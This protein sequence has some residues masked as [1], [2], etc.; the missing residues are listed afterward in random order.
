[1]NANF[2]GV[3]RYTYELLRRFPEKVEQISPSQ[4]FS[5]GIKGHIWEQLFLP[6]KLNGSLL[7]SPSNTGPVLYKNQIVVLHDIV[8][9]DHPEWFNK[10]FTSWYNFLLPKLANNAKHILTIS[11]FTKDRIIKKL[12][13]S[14]SKISVVHNGVDHS[15]LSHQDKKV[16]LPYQRYILALGSIEPRKNLIRLVQAWNN[17][18]DKLPS[19]IGLVIAGKQGNSLIF[20][21]VEFG[22]KMENVHFTGYVEEN[23]MAAL[24]ANA[25]CFCYLSSYEGFGL[26]PLEAMACGC[27]VIVGNQ[28]SLPEVVGNAGIQVD[29]FSI[30]EIENAI[31]NYV[32]NDSLIKKYSDLGLTHSRNFNWD[33]TAEKTWKLLKKMS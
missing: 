2:T 30:I 12:R 7:F 24:Y 20:N 13:I 18:K 28:T 31:L 23:E 19:D 5:R 33:I 9:I 8:T 3:Q 6:R 22:E 1:M 26:P 16:D 11:D 10:K 4:K 14:E 21:N 15:F 27:P 29:P 17:I 32:N 25:L